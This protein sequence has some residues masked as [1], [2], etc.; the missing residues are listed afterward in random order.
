MV[1]A[2]RENANGFGI[3]RMDALFGLSWGGER[4][5]FG[6]EC[7]ALGLWRAFWLK[8]LR[9]RSKAI[10]WKMRGPGVCWT[11]KKDE[12]ELEGE[13]PSITAS[14]LTELDQNMSSKAVH[15]CSLCGLRPIGQQHKKTVLE[16]QES[17][18]TALSV[19][20]I[21]GFLIVWTSSTGHTVLSR[22]MFHSFSLIPSL[23]TPT[24]P[25]HHPLACDF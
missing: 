21:R 22:K 5:S 17:K 23:A 12:A 25:P 8:S 13:L 3:G 15:G 9:E 7:G 16:H 19:V 1:E 2:G 4:L 20:I 14:E 18:H 24:L 11:V 10:E 6:G